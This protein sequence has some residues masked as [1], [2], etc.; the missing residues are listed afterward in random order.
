MGK[1]AKTSQA[2][3]SIFGSQQWIAEGIKTTPQ[4][5]S[6]NVTVTEYVRVSVV[7]SGSGIN[8]DSVSGLILIDIFT[9]AGNGPIRANIIADKLDSYLLGKSFTEAALG[10]VTQI[11]KTSSLSTQGIDKA[12]PALF[13]TKYQAQFNHFLSEV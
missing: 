5:F 3:F 10:A 8:Q 12:N 6:S 13:H 7:P 2:I 4:N 11:Q 1:F 9:A